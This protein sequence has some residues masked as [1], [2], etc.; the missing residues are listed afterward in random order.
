[1]SGD[2]ARYRRLLFLDL[3]GACTPDERRA[4]RE[5]VAACAACA[6]EREAE[7]ALG[8]LLGS[9][10]AAQRPPR[11]R[12]RG[13]LALGGAAALLLGAQLI[14][15][16]RPAYGSIHSARL[17]TVTWQDG[18]SERL[19]EANHLRIP[20]GASA[21]VAVEGVGTVGAVGP[22]VF[23]LDKTPAGWKVCLF[24]GQLELAVHEGAS[25]S[26]SSEAGTRV[27][28]GGEWVVDLNGGF[29]EERAVA[30]LDS[31]A[32]L[33]NRGLGVF[34]S[35]R[36]EEGARDLQAVL[37]HPDL[38]AEKR[39][40]ALFYLA[41]VQCN[42]D[43]HA[44]ALRTV[45]AWLAES[46]D[47]HSGR[48][49]A[50]SWRGSCLW[51]LGRRE[52][53][54][55]QWRAVL[56][57]FP[58]TPYRAYMHLEP[59]VGAAH[60]AAHAAARP[61]AVTRVAAGGDGGGY[62][63]LLTALDPERAEHAAFR[64][65]GEE[66]ARYHDGAAVAFDGRDFDGL[67]ERLAARAPENVLVVVPPERFDVDLHRRLLL[68][69]PGLDADPFCDFALGYF[70]ARDGAA[71]E[72]LW[73]RTRRMHERGLRNEVWMESSVIASDTPSFVSGTESLM[74]FVRAAGFRGKSLHWTEVG[75]DPGVV[76]FLDEHLDALEEAAVV[77]MSGN[78]DPQG[79][80]L[81]DGQ[82]NLDAS[83]HWPY[84]PARVGEDP[85]GVMPRIDAA[86]FRALDLDGA[87]LW[88]GTCHSGATRR[89]Y[90]EGDIVST[91]GKSERCELY[92]LAPDES[93][94]LAFLDAGATALLVPVASNH[95]W[96][97]INEAHFALGNGASLGEVVQSTWNDVCFAAG[98]APDLHMTQVGEAHR[99]GLEHV[100]HGAGCNRVLIGD[101]E[102]RPFERSEHPTERVEVARDG[103]S[104]LLVTVDW[105]PGFHPW[106]WNPYASRGE[107]DARIRARVD[108][109]EHLPEHVD[110][111]R[112][113]AR[114]DFGG[115]EDVPHEV[116]SAL[117]DY[118]GRRYLHL[119]AEHRRPRAPHTPCRARFELS[120]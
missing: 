98:G 19:E 105:Q 3:E 89:V 47:D 51:E 95:G 39:G 97:T 15:A 53:A 14:T 52:E 80:W 115:D 110:A 66:I 106:A 83:L 37:V 64:A 7:R 29:F 100:M 91:F 119:Q 59:A 82:R 31:V 30:P 120:W 6:G 114:V 103:A 24:R 73:A 109:T 87:V 45:D 88:S 50:L 38:D 96:S 54:Q 48:E 117:E 69:A 107:P 43:R 102:L 26:V 76:E 56:A 46:P 12:A 75:Y 62:L 18:A 94:A 27:V 84:D 20:A 90:V 44:E 99:F 35:R 55:A 11:A 101:P 93:L 108:V 104:G 40:Q 112:V 78:G 70:T 21:L 4:L 28:G 33:L 116:R 71:L 86:R 10:S 65:V 41:A 77:A 8:A 25:L 81:F 57:E 16:G 5:H 63:V 22:A 42:L 1:M 17:L 61:A 36:W 111:I 49:S 67:R 74:D 60:A 92:E 32:A 2:C 23:E 85:E 113:R 68:L 58:S 13:W 72:E 118:H 79:V 34:V 9:P